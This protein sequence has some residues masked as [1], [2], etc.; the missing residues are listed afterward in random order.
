M[1]T[2]RDTPIPEAS[3]DAPDLNLPDGLQIQAFNDFEAALLELFK[4]HGGTP[5]Q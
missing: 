2:D 4:K 5:Y 3:A 1:T